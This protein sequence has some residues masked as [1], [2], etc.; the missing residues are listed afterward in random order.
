MGK[1]VSEKEWVKSI[2]T[3]IDKDI[4]K[5]SGNLFVEDGRKLPYAYE[6]ME[7]DDDHEKNH[8][9]NYL[10]YETDILIYEKT[11][12]E[13]WKPRIVIEAKVDSINTH[14]AI[15]Y[16]QKS[17]THKNVHP[18]LRYGIIIGNREHYPLPG[19]LFRHGVHFDFM[20]SWKGHRPD[21]AEWNMF[22]KILKDEIQASKHLE[23]IIFNSRS[24]ERIKYVC[25]HKP[26]RL[27]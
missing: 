22:I 25:L 18:Y 8:K 15:T 19:R 7:Y 17:L 2:I 20:M 21:I 13:K 9:L 1:Q 16:S 14:D 27:K 23:E 4:K 5:L 3:N 10:S 6:V 12:K 26:L 11:G 24:K